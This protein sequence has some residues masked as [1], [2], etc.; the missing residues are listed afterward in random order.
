MIDFL[1]SRR[2][3]RTFGAAGLACL[4]VLAGAPAFAQ[5]ST[6]YDPDFAPSA[7]QPAPPPTA[8]PAASAPAA[9]EAAPPALVV[10][11]APARSRGAF[12]LF[13][14]SD[15]DHILEP[16]ASTAA[17]VSAAPSEGA[18]PQSTEYSLARFQRVHAAVDRGEEPG[19]EAS[20]L[21]P[22]WSAPVVGVEVST[23]APKPPPPEIE[24]PTYGTSLSV[25][26]RK[27][28][29]F[30]YTLTHYTGDQST[31][32]RPATT[33]LFQITQQL[34]LRMQ[35]KV[36]PKITVNVD[37]DDTKTNQ[38][39]ISVVYNGDPNEVVQNVSFGDIDLTLPATEFVSYNK[40]L[41]GIRADV[42]YKGF[43]STIIASRTKGTTKSKQF[44][45]NSQFVTEDILDTA[46][47]RRTYYDLTFGDTARLPIKPASERVFL[48][49]QS[50]L[51]TNNV[52]QQ[53]LTVDDLAVPTS[54]ITAVFTQ[55][56][57][58]QDYTIN[59]AKGYI[60]FRNQM[61]P[62]FVVAVDYVDANGNE[63][64][65]QSSATAI[66]AG[67]TG[68]FKL[69]K[70]SGDIPVSTTTEVGYNR[71]MKTFYSMGQT[72]IVADN[73]RGNFL[74]QVLD[75]TSRALLGPSLNPVQTYPATIQVDFANGIF[76][77]L[78]PF[79]AS[80]ATPNV[81][82]PNIYAPAPISQ[83]I[84]NAQFNY[85]FKTFTIEPNLVVQSEL[86]VLDGQKL[87]RNVDYFI[88]Y[89]AGFL[90]FFNPDRIL[91]TSEIDITYE[92]AAF[93]G[94][95]NDTLLGSRVSYDITKNISM[96][97]TLLYDA[98]TKSPT[99][100][101]ITELARSLLVYEFDTQIK[102]VKIGKKFTMTLQ[103]EFAQSHQDMNLN[104][105][106]IVDNMEGILLQN[107]A[108][109]LYT[110]WYIA[111]NPGTVPSDPSKIT[112]A[113]ETD[114]ILAINPNAQAGSNATQQVLDVSYN[115]SN[116]ASQEMSIAYPF[117]LSGIDFSKYTLLQ[118]VMAGD[119]GNEQL[120]FHL[121]G[122]DEDADGTGGET[123]NCANGTVV[124]GAPKTED[125]DCT[126]ILT[127]SKDIGWCY[128][129]GGNA[130]AAR[131]GAN[132]GILDSEDLN[133]NGHLD[134]PDFTG[135][136]FGYVPD[137]N[138][139]TNNQFFDATAAS[140]ITAIS[141]GGVGFHTLQIPLNISSATTANWNA[142]K[143]I[144]LSIKPGTLQSGTLR[145]ASISVVGNT[146]LPGAAGDPN[147]G[148]GALANEAM[149]VSPINNVNNSNYVPIYNAGGDASNVFND[150][151]GS[152]S[153]LQ[154]LSNTS[155]ISEQALDMK[156]SGLAP[157]ATVYTKRVFSSAI[158]ISQHR[159]FNFL[160]YGNADPS[161]IEL[162]GNQVFFLRAGTDNNY[163]E[164]D[165]P[166]TFTGWKLITVNQ[167]DPGN[168]VTNGWVADTPGTVIASTGAPSLQ[169]VG[170]FVAGMY[171]QNPKPGQGA[172]RPDG[173]VYLDEI[174]MS[175]PI[176]RTGNA[177]KLQ[178]DFE[179][180]GWGTMGYKLKS[181]D[182]DFQTPTSVVSN[183]A[184]RIDNAYLN[185]TRLSW[186]PVTMSESRQITDTPNTVATGNLSNLVNLLQQGKVTTWNTAAQ[187]NVAYGAYPRLNLGYT[188][189]I[190]DYD[191]L[192]R[193]D[194]KQTLS[195]TM[196]YGLHSQSHWLPHTVDA[197]YAATFY[198]VRFLSAL[199]RTEIGDYDTSEHDGTYGGRLTFTPWT[200]ASFNPSFAKTV[201]TER[202]TDYTS[203]A[204][205]DSSY[206]K[207]LHQTAGFTSNWRL[208]KWLNPQ[209][210]YS[211]DDLE[212]NV[213]SVSSISVGVSTFSFNPGD[214]KTVTR[215]ANGTIS[216]PIAIA[217]I[218]PKTKLFHSLNVITGYQLQDGDVW[219]NIDKDVNTASLFFVRQPIRDDS[220]PTATLANQTL[221]D[222]FNSTQR[223]SP[224]DQYKFAGRW[225]PLHTLSI[226]N[227]FVYSVQRSDTTGTET[228]TIT[229]TLPDIVASISQLEKM[230]RTEKWMANTQLNLK[231]SLRTT[232]TVGATLNTVNSFGTDLR[233]VILKKYD[234]SLSGNVILTSNKDLQVSANTQQTE[235]EDATGQVTFDVK[236]FRLTPKI[237]Y[238]RDVTNLGTGIQSANTQVITPSVLAR[239]D[240][241]L[242]AGLRLPGSSRPL[243]FTNRVIWT[244]TASFA[245]SESPVTPAN[246][247]NV[248]TLNTSAD[249]EI[250]KNLRMT[251]NGAATRNWSYALP[252]NSFYSFTLGT[253]LTFQ[254]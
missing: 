24:L 68:R 151:Y 121:G 136:D 211:M 246:D 253:T 200:G 252:V 163:W 130:C 138:N 161:N 206:P 158:D 148:S 146:W 117:S 31:T 154:Q 227:N 183:Q 108:P 164:V 80:S 44:L 111:S 3:G 207:L 76:Q 201:G 139:P 173:T 38:Q 9:A 17:A 230:W 53:S 228:K 2:L 203:G 100:P 129:Y 74:L 89:E 122:I 188:R 126:G 25:T 254:F 28:I 233:S 109:M 199:S 86:V 8:P 110:S 22:G 59:Y 115:F 35:G 208:A 106:A 192:T 237:T 133:K 229:K 118:V 157:G 61:Q 174:F 156:Y 134:P 46:Y 131:Y 212:N 120:N 178:A 162:D 95:T 123:L 124:T 152:I 26:G 112:W 231:Y 69:I 177:E 180:A 165:V 51:T 172:P 189:N 242:P 245:H 40:Q 43:K 224:F 81:I 181:V 218:F 127:P 185:I 239:A 205:V 175:V 42:K 84:I 235:H 29:G 194:D 244:T 213:L 160:L 166:I 215:Q 96:G 79:S 221:R 11:A 41:F 65:F 107:Q 98:G 49:Q 1:Q 32:G 54:T 97:S 250:A 60:Q 101:Q 197:N 56:V 52:N 116:P 34:Q 85:R 91:P 77:L 223:W 184:N 170:E 67:G 222:T 64:V 71:E 15:A 219:N 88:D 87:N 14:R 33:D 251:L 141:F 150:L 73:G 48:S 204:P 241:A 119:S 128:A 70:T 4:A 238:A 66:I 105:Y 103:G 45:G 72:S 125:T 176:Q 75:P 30:N 63:L 82:D 62:Q 167:N 5:F 249:Y 217:D 23:E 187:A 47:L 195:G 99:T 36:G 135:G 144:R 243:L 10:P 20:L 137:P 226:S 210:T 19:E 236:K 55:L 216:L 159:Q 247:T 225:G 57:S 220:N 182:A 198:D 149:I 147:L 92:V 18:P 234:T 168:G 83:R 13:D 6:P 21:G 93:A 186:L 94:T 145:F 169:T 58:G 140:T 113:T 114:N 78:Q 142:V 12:R 39:D 193:Q 232:E 240:L 209:M 7:Q 190:I 132:N 102:K 191:L 214:V 155:N 153:N 202:R 248:A 16:L 37:Y 179:Y 171:E 27:V 143:Q 196:Q 90:T 50:L 104:A